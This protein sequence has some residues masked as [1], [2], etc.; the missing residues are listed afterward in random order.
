MIYSIHID[1]L[2]Q[3]VCFKNR[4]F[5]ITYFYYVRSEINNGLSA[6]LPTHFIDKMGDSVGNNDAKYLSFFQY[7]CFEIVRI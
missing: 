6:I 2:D 7:L 3:K 4:K 5:R 1:T